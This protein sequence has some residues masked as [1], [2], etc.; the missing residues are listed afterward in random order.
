MRGTHCA[1]TIDV[2]AVGIRPFGRVEREEDIQRRWEGPEGDS[3]RM[4]G[5]RTEE[6]QGL[7]GIELITTFGTRCCLC[8]ISRARCKD[9]MSLSSIFVN[10][11]D[12]KVSAV[13][14]ESEQRNQRTLLQTSWGLLWLLMEAFDG[15]LVQHLGKHR[16]VQRLP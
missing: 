3:G 6:S 12:V 16:D 10:N 5:G 2:S 14:T 7:R 1:C 13:S 4:E 8:R 11:L 9:G 15:I